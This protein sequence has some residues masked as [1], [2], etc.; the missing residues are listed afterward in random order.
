MK[1]IKKWISAGFL[2]LTVCAMITGVLLVNAADYET[3]AFFSATG[4]ALTVTEDYDAGATSGA[5]MELSGTDSNFGTAT[6]EYNDAI[7]VDQLD[8][9]ITF[10]VLPQNDGEVDFDA[11]Q[12]ILR[13]SEDP[14]QLISVVVK[15]GCFDVP[16]PTPNHTRAYAFLEENF[17]MGSFGDVWYASSV[18]DTANVFSKDWFVGFPNEGYTEM[19]TMGL[20]NTV[21]GSIYPWLAAENK[22]E[23]QAI[24][25][26]YENNT[27]YVNGKEVANLKN[28]FY[29]NLNRQ[30]LDPVADAA[31]LEKLT[32][33]YVDGLFSS[34]KVTFELKFHNISKTG[35]SVN[36]ANMGDTMFAK[37]YENNF[38]SDAETKAEGETESNVQQQTGTKFDL[39]NPII[40]PEISVETLD[41]AITFQMLNNTAGGLACE[42]IL[43]TLRDSQDPS[44]II[45]IIIQKSDVWYEEKNTGAFA[46]LE[47][48]YVRDGWGYVKLKATENRPSEQQQFVVSHDRFGAAG[49]GDDN[50]SA[51]G[52]FKVYNVTNTYYGLL[53]EEE[54]KNTR[55]I[56]ISYTDS[57]VYVNG[58]LIADLKND[59]YQRLSTDKL[60]AETDQGII[61]KYTDEYIDG[62][63]SSG[64]VI[65]ELRFSNNIDGSV[66]VISLG[67]QSAANLQIDYSAPQDTLAPEITAIAGDTYNAENKTFTVHPDTAYTVSELAQITAS[68]LLDPAPVTGIEAYSAEGTKYETE[69]V[70][71]AEGDYVILFAEDADGNRTEVRAE[72]SFLPEY[73]ITYTDKSGTD[74]TVVQGDEYTF[75]AP[76]AREG[77]VFA[78]W[79]IGG[80]LYPA[81][82]KIT[83]TENI[84]VSALFISFAT[85]EAEM[86]GENAIRY[87]TRVDSED[88]TALESAAKELQFGTVITCDSKAGHLDIETKV[89]VS[90]GAAEGCEEYRAVFTDIPEEMFDAIFTATGY[91]IVTYENGATASV[92]AEGIEA[93]V[94]EL[95]AEV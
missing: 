57:C 90:E 42:D 94:N 47:N 12:V 38:I 81:D 92:M 59:N 68:D 61:D 23:T 51:Y 79:Q 43:V 40:L 36:I 64:K 3:E 82:Y 44:E 30:E 37:P 41:N 86:A 48:E 13:D 83:V 52:T 69:Q 89:W 4:G 88:Y 56:N 72:I 75:A 27:V 29:Q 93:S 84:E 60:S 20:S 78:G 6:I 63:F 39:T 7:P 11:V 22:A 55:L 65:V 19:G 58:V 5:K 35:I 24:S 45:N 74:A 25:V 76:A 67:G 53:G 21:F 46:L 1:K 80:K 2:A 66:N 77:E 9:A 26:S 33:E 16:T 14:S 15:L 8:S 17:T 62:L 18:A 71:F 91:V 32:D 31:I 50:Y 54:G 49:V 87:F 95:V 73:T 28:D 70:T 34:G 85:D 10:Q